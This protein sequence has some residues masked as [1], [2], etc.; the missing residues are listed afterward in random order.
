M[1]S[2]KQ[3]TNQRIIFDEYVKSCYKIYNEEEEKHD[4][5]SLRLCY[6]ECKDC[7]YS[8]RYIDENGNFKLS[9]LLRELNI[10]NYDNNFEKSPKSSTDYGKE[11]F[12]YAKQRSQELG[13]P[14]STFKTI[15]DT[16]ERA[17]QML[18]EWWGQ[19]ATTEE[20]LDWFEGENEIMLK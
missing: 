3:Q 7:K 14:K 15:K 11:F 1:T 12:D 17:T 20:M 18:H 4:M 13:M 5:G 19:F 8:H 2:I 10:T 16:R 9:Y 6:E